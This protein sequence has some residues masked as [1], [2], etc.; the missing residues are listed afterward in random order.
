MGA[1]LFLAHELVAGE[2]QFEMNPGQARNGNAE[3]SSGAGVSLENMS[4]LIRLVSGEALQF[5]PGPVWQKVGEESAT[6][7]RSKDAAI[8]SA[9]LCGLRR[10]DFQIE[11][12]TP[13][14]SPE[15]SEEINIWPREFH[16][17]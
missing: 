8:S 2:P 11:M 5:L 1:A 7:F 12:R 16:D 14:D 6:L 15:K 10:E 13:G 4:F 9:Y 17:R 3:Q